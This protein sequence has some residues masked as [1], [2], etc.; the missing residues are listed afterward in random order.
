M[1]KQ[2]Y[3]SP[4][5]DQLLRKDVFRRRR[6]KLSQ[7]EA[8]RSAFVV[9]RRA[10]VLK[11]LKTDL[12][13]DL[14]VSEAA[15]ELRSALRDHQVVV[16]AGETGSGKTTQL[17]KLLL[18]A[19][20]GVRGSIA[21]TQPRRLAA[22]TVANRIADETG[23]ELG[24]GVGF[25]VRFSDAVSE[26]T[27]LKV[28]TDGLLLN[29]IRSDRFLDAYDAI[30]IDEA[31]ERSLNVDFLLGYL[32][33]LLARRKDLKV[34]VTSAT[35]DVE[36][37]SKF[38]HNAPVVK[39]GGRT[40]PVEVIYQEEPAELFDGVVNALRNIETRPYQGAS[41]VLVFC[42]GERD[43]FDLAHDLRH[44]Y[45]DRYEVLPLYARLSFAEQRRVFTVSKAKRRIVLATNVAETSIT[46]PNI[47]F[48]IDPGLAR[49]NRYSYRTKL[50]RLPIEPIAKASADQRKG[51]CGRIAPGVCYRLFS[52]HDF[53]ARPEFTDPE[54]RRV[55]LAGVVLQM[56]AFNLGEIQTFPFVD[57]PDPRAIKD[58]LRLLDELQAI[59]GGR[60]SKIGLQMARLPIDPRLARM[61]VEANQQGSLKELLIIVSG[62]AVQD[63]R[64]RPM[65][66]AQAA[67]QSHLAFTEP[68]SDFLGYLK[69]WEWL[70][71]EKKNL[72][73]SRFKQVLAKR[74]VNF[75]RVREWREV[76]RQLR[77]VCRD[78]GWRPNEDPASYG[79][80]HEAIVSGSLSLVAQHD[81]RGVY[82]GARNLRLRIFPGSGLADKTPKWIV[83]GEIAE[84]SRVYG[85]SIAKVEPGWIERHGQHLVKKRYSEPSWSPKRGEVTA[86]LTVTLYGLVLADNRLVGYEKIDPT[87]CRDLFIRD[88]LVAGALEPIPKF[89]LANMKLVRQI[90]D[91]EAKERRRD[92]LIGDDAMYAFYDEKLPPGM[93]RAEDLRRW[94][95]KGNNT[96]V[97]SFDKRFLQQQRSTQAAE[98]MYP[99][100]MVMGDL[101][102]RLNY[103]FA[104]GESDDGV[105]LII[106]VGLLNEVR[107]EVLEWSVPGF[108]AS[109]VEA[110]LR[111][112]PKGKRKK[113]APM[114]EK[115]EEIAK[116]LLGEGR[117]REGRLL[118]QLQNVLQDWYRLE[119]EEADWDRA[120]IADH[121]RIY[122]SVV[123]ER[124]KQLRGGRNVVEIKQT[125][126][127]QAGTI[128]TAVIERKEARGLTTFPD[129]QVK[130]S[131]VLG[132]R[133]NQVMKF[134]GFVDQVTT[135]DIRLFDDRV[136][137]DRAHRDGLVRLALLGLGKVSRYFR[138][139]LDKHPQMGL[140]FAAL[141]SASELKDEIL[142]AVV[143]RCY[144]EDRGL[145][146][147]KAEFEQCLQ[148]YRSDL[149]AVFTSTVDALAEILALRFEC[150]KRL[151]RLD[152]KAYQISKLDIET[153]LNALV[154]REVL[155][156]TPARYF[157][158]VPR[159]L[160]GIERRLENL[161]GHVPKDQK[162]LFL[163][164]PFEDRLAR[165][166][167]SELHNENAEIDLR[168][169]LQEVRL[170]LFAE[171]IA[172]QKV[173]NHPLIEPYGKQWKASPKRLEMALS[174]EERRLGIL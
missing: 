47:G 14:P 21:H 42:S 137:R 154:P 13:P 136:T 119:V 22:R 124:G 6:G 43:I 45:P 58:A 36:R 27:L 140:H 30:I 25:A 4:A 18:Q 70:E 120:R 76:H 122:A 20:F 95:D 172:R 79:A 168:F 164:A 159:Y 121:L 40:F 46:V 101:R 71:E 66:K 31:H 127:A 35:I 129:A 62:L 170:S 100:E 166:S 52:S 147:D 160:R 34:V 106:P 91:Q 157:E 131:L 51:R 93:C 110:W 94:L 98:G 55:N 171:P 53:D 113:L 84:T 169:L 67:D 44:A 73:N 103:R 17:P 114:P 162:Q 135:V 50:Q 88:G 75:L 12:M 167:D 32:K 174:E 33:R 39:V 92:L 29:E 49:I 153:Q 126:Q 26:E 155:N 134:P 24:K 68:R 10:E 133:T 5:D 72:T 151:S 148:L 173:D 41:D 130:E 161:P 138:R 139:E 89:L 152:S 63:P 112:L 118:S 146:V 82:Q 102:L 60:L 23:C 107:A 158:L 38:F 87:I 97:L 2:V 64:E 56:Q 111:T 37:F 81:E 115:V 77:S 48:V 86:K 149:A 1:T 141:G 57:P 19:G 116:F 96:Q 80:I 145:P 11:A 3:K 90:Q 123:D 83:A 61:M 65:Q 7:K 28:M 163:I 144:F 156:V 109:V 69:L 99:G 59:K 132:K 108:F 15:E 9:K 85:R 8:E 74:F 125:L 16:V 142:R 78:S 143:W 165:L 105:R 150:G 54:I 117:Y 104:P 128:P